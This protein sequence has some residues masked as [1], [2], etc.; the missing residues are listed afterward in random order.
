MAALFVAGSLRAQSLEQTL[1]YVRES[2]DAHAVT[3]RIEPPTRISSVKWQVSKIEGCAVELKE[4]DHRESADSV[5]NHNGVF[6]LDEDRVITWS[7]DLGDL[8]P[9]F[10]MADTSTGTPHIKV[11]AEGDAFHTK[12]ETT[13]RLMRKDGSVESTQTWSSARTQR[14]LQLNF[15]SPAIDNK[16]LVHRLELDLRDAVYACSFHASR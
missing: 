8:L 1:K 15:D 3:H 12:T 4:T 13:S 7:F 5:V 2:I 6:S 11:F 9:Q 10:V 16:A 14:N